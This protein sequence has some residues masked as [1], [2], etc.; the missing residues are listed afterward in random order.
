MEEKRDSGYFNGEKG[1]P[2]DK[3]AVLYTEQT[4]TEA[5]KTQARE[6]IGAASQAEAAFFHSRLTDGSLVLEDT[7]TSDSYTLRVHKGKLEMNGAT[8]L[9][10]EDEQR[11]AEEAKAGSVL[12]TQQDL[13]EEQK[14]SARQNIGAAPNRVFVK[15]DEVQELTH[16]QMST[17]RYNINAAGLDQVART[18]QSQNLSEE[19][20]AQARAN[21]GAISADEIPEGGG[22]SVDL[23]GYVKD[24]D[25]A[26]A[27]K[28]GVVKVGTG[29]S[30]TSDGKCQIEY[31]SQ[32][33][34]AS[35][36]GYRN[37][38]VPQFID[39]IVKAGITTNQIP[40]T[41]EEQQA[42]KNWLGVEI[43]AGGGDKPLELIRTVTIPA[44][45]VTDESGVTWGQS[46]GDSTKPWQWEITTDS[47]GNPFALKYFI[48]IHRA[49]TGNSS[50]SASQF[51]YINDQSFSAPGM[52]K[53]TSD[54]YGGMCIWDGR[55]LFNTP[56][57]GMWNSYNLQLGRIEG[58]ATPITFGVETAN[59]IKVQFNIR[60]A[61]WSE[62]TT[63]DI[64]GVRV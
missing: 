4:L 48:I 55:L 34:I 60:G 6:N 2:G 15:A 5:Q 51:I 64:Y 1:D 37:P 40:L 7:K 8:F 22:G 12:Y 36:Q 33:S 54:N 62:G 39:D 46:S 3:D 29:F 38:L 23:T 28:A 58:N 14:A 45:I 9:T 63:F 21:I 47:A 32:S 10:N 27:D 30:V 44:D 43:P 26:T 35:K 52:G 17:A 59:K 61:H 50:A 49:P 13:T 53:S 31:A 56:L 41:A 16:Q 18:D 11:I 25:Y 57:T 19:Q 24:T 42:A 20:K